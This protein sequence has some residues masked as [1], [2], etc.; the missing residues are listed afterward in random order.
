MAIHTQVSGDSMKLEISDAGRWA[1][2][3]DGVFEIKSGLCAVS[4][5]GETTHSSC[6]KWTLKKINSMT[7]DDPHGES[8]IIS[9][10]FTAPNDLDVNWISGIYNDNTA[11]WFAMSVLNTGSK[12]VFLDALIPIYVR[13]EKGGTLQMCGGGGQNDWRALHNDMWMGTNKPAM[14]TPGD[15]G[16]QDDY[17]VSALCNKNKSGCIAAGMGERTNTITQI[18]W[19]RRIGNFEL[20]VKG[21]TMVNRKGTPLRLDPGKK[22]TM[23]RVVLMPGKYIFDCLEAYGEYLAAYSRIKM[24]HKPYTGIFC[25]YGPDKSGSEDWQ[26]H[27]L[28]YDRV[29]E[30]M[31]I[32][33]KYLKP[34]GFDYIKTQF[35]GLSS[36]PGQMIMS[37]REW[38][39]NP[40]EPAADSPAELA[41]VIE[42][43]G[44][45]PDTCNLNE[46]QPRGVNSLSDAVHGRGYK[47]ALVCRAFLNV[48]CGSAERDAYA[49]EIFAMCVKKW[50]YDYLM[51]DFVSA[52]FENDLDDSITMAQSISNR[53]EA[54]RNAVGKNIFIEACMC[55]I[56]PVIG[57][58]DGYR[59]ASDWR[60]GTEAKLSG[61][62]LGYY[63]LHGKIFQMDLEFFD[64]DLTPFIWLGSPENSRRKF[65]GS[66]DRVR[67]WITYSALTGFSLL[68]GG[69]IDTVS[70]ER[71]RI[72]TRAM[73]VYGKCA[74][75]LS[76]PDGKP[77]SIMALDIN[78]K[79][80]P[81]IVLGL[82]NWDS[83][84]TETKTLQFSELGLEEND[85]IL[86]YDFW[87][88]RFLGVYSG[89]YT[90]NL[91]PC[92][93]IALLIHKLNSNPIYLGNNRHVTGAFGC[94][95]ITFDN[96]NYKISGISE[97][98]VNETVDHYIFIPSGQGA[99]HTKNCSAETTQPG[100]IRVTVT[101]TAE[102]EIL[103]AVTLSDQHAAI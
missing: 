58:A 80:P 70:P 33:D 26:S 72:F 6:D 41:S 39:L 67:S 3:A 46:I 84:A 93:C 57:L 13:A 25:A 77:V 78:D 62:M 91:P 74:K 16:M 50:G 94:K 37:R 69:I 35:G 52:D 47:H 7:N 101:H 89:R 59:P 63:F 56:G 48:E 92:G 23:N 29:L 65:F 20:A 76:L 45:T 75:P 100:V 1:L 18:G 24:E 98:P 38:T 19:T 53:F 10:D 73:P 8:K 79:R 4:F 31:D 103:W 30:L 49:A 88:E 28:N 12:P 99:A 5:A 68:T 36:G 11:A 32:T 27:V 44:F 43:K 86:L 90:Y 21:L 82:F 22:F 71:W 51:C 40:I 87:N 55:M 66:I 15:V 102:T 83:S 14:Y 60:G 42:E 97:A 17:H 64:P 34:Y 54:I 81:Y 9:A 61:E 85:S 95:S 96:E 2:K